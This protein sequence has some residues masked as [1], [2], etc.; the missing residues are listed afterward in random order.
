MPIPSVRETVRDGGLGITQ[1][2]TMLPIVLGVSSAGTTNVLE[3]YSSVQSLHDGRGEGNAVETAAN[4][5]A[6]GGGPIG[7]LGL[8]STIAGTNGSVSG[9]AGLAISGEANFDARI[10]V[11]IMLGG[12]LGVAKFR[13]CLDGY[14]GDTASERT[15]S[16]TLTVPGGGTYAFPGLGITGT[17]SGTLV[18][19]TVYTADVVAGAA[20]ATDLN[21][22]MAVVKATSTDFRSVVV[23]T[24]KGN[25]DAT[26][27]ALLAA[28]LQ[29]HLAEMQTTGR[30]R[31]GMIATAHGD[32]AAA[33]ATAF[34]STTATRLLLTY[35]MVRRAST[36]PLP[37]FAFPVTNSLDCFAARAAASLAGTDLK[38]V[39]SGPLQ[40]VVKT[41]H[42]EYGTPSAL[43]DMKISTLRSWQ[44][45]NGTYITEGK[46]KSPNGSDFELWAHGILMDIACDTAHEAMID[47]IGRGVRLQ[48]REING[49]PFV[50][51]IDDRDAAKIEQS[52][53]SALATQL[54]NVTDAE[55]MPG[56]VT[57]LRF[58]I[59]RTT[60]IAA[61]GVMK[62]RVGIQ[63]KGYISFIEG[64]LGFVV[65][66]LTA[67]A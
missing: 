52:A 24:G 60:N 65:E 18:L 12:A 11:E 32:S 19:N 47:E 40:E 20:N 9:G 30:H 50:G 25:G 41:F 57:A 35:G 1:L 38:R 10:R 59:D 45:K 14:A 48:S 15:Y 21:A 17:F 67:A 56:F 3:I 63:P 16:E 13:Y 34:A 33:V 5:L 66:I 62:Y 2:A 58:E 28:A 46:L 55:G 36:K 6:M 37:G 31:R 51:T 44:G 26:A 64:E 4:I 49:V 43:N 53:Y 22:G 42:D 8:D 39:R 29:T 23:V 54:L 61:T 27:H 7:F